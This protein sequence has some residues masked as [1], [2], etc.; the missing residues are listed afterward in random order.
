V[1]G[2]VLL[3][4]LPARELRELRPHMDDV[5]LEPRSFYIGAG[6][7]LSHVYFPVTGLV[8]L[9]VSELAGSSVQAAA[10]GRDG[11]LGVSAILEA[12]DPPFEMVCLVRG[13]ALRMHVAQFAQCMHE[14]PYFR[15]ALLRYS[16]ALLNEAVRTAAC[17]GLH[18]IQQ[19]LAR[20]LL[21]ACDRLETEAFPLTHSQLGHM[22]GATRALVT[23]TLH[24]MQQS[25]LLHHQRGMLRILDSTGLERIACEDYAAIRTPYAHLAGRARHAFSGED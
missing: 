7:R 8:S 15:C 11:M 9:M 13:R 23:Q 16:H 20:C 24:A 10:A 5:E 3:D 14:L 17:N 19:R 2:N 1:S 6:E 18:P 12:N 25:G 21:L 4:G 22:L